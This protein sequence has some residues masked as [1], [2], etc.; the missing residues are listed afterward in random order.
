MTAFEAGQAVRKTFN[1]IIIAGL[2]A[3]V[4]IA[5]SGNSKWMSGK[6]LINLFPNSQKSPEQDAL[7]ASFDRDNGKLYCVPKMSGEELGNFK[8]RIPAMMIQGAFAEAFSGN[9]DTDAFEK[10]PMESVLR[11]TFTKSYP[12]SK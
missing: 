11:M 8:A 1:Y 12:C 6:E 4:V 3:A 10:K 7:V 2:V 5:C 9:I